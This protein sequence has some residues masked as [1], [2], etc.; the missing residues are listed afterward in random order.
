MVVG[1]SE[2]FAR[3]SNIYFC[4]FNS[5][6]FYNTKELELISLDFDVL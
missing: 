6:D 5:F 4:L 3:F 2:I 1:V